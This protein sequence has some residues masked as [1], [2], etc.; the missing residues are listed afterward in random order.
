MENAAR[1]ICSFALAPRPTPASDV[2]HCE[3]AGYHFRQ[4]PCLDRDDGV[5]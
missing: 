3:D 4:M 1:G 2:S 5:A